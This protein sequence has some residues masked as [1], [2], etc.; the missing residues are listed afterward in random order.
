MKM[1]AY[2]AGVKLDFI[3]PGRPF[4]NGFMESSAVVDKASN[5]CLP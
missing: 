3:Q 1:W 4:Q 2:Q 5:A